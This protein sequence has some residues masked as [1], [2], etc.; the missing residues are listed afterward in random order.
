VRDGGEQ[1]GRAGGL[2]QRGGGL[3]QRR[4]EQSKGGES[5]TE[6]R[7]RRGQERAE[8]KRAE[9]GWG[10]VEV[11]MWQRQKGLRKFRRKGPNMQVFP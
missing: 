7:E 4:G 9:G 10:M 6:Q 8:E 2:E 5:R 1:R 11:M 3:E